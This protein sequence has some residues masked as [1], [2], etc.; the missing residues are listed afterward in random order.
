M[1]KTIHTVTGPISTDKLGMTLMHEHI[2]VSASGAELD[3]TVPHDKG[4]IIEEAVADLHELP[5]LGVKS[6][7]DPL[8][9]D[10]GRDVEIMREVSRQ[11]GLNV[12][13]ATGFYHEQ[14][15][16]P[17]HFRRRNADQLA[18]TMVHEI[19]HGVGKTGIHPGIIKCASWNTPFSRAEE[20]AIRAAGRAH[21]ATGTPITTHTTAGTYGPQQLDLLQEE[22][23]SPERVIVGHCC[24]SS[25]LRYLKSILDRGA[26][27][28]ID[29]IGS[30]HFNTDDI[31]AGIVAGVIGM[32]Y[33]HKLV[34]SMDHV[35]CFAF[36]YTMPLNL[37]VHQPDRTDRTF[38]DI[39]DTFLPALKKHGI[40]EETLHHIMVDNPRKFFEG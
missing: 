36:G 29:Q 10:L 25:D 22:G 38:T 26:W 18:E 4:P 7:V 3:P 33:M 13:A 17:T 23:V 31:R 6:I 9:I 1:P 14:S 2:K 11:L 39:F 30:A 19:T 24:A 12:I 15:G 37:P 16:L 40:T 34:I 8:P 35:A 21:R 27:I 5:R 20:Q 28:G 32:G